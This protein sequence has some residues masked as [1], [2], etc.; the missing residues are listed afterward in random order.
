MGCVPG[1]TGGMKPKHQR[2]RLIVGGL[3]SLGAGAA[4]VFSLRDNL[5]TPLR[6]TAHLCSSKP[7]IRVGLVASFRG[8]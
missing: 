6:I 5:P 3:V 8:T 4:S 7:R 2:L 1:K